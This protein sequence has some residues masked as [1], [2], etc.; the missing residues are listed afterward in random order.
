MLCLFAF[1]RLSIPRGAGKRSA[2]LLAHRHF[3]CMS[4]T[5]AELY[6]VVKTEFERHVAPGRCT[7]DGQP[8]GHK[9]VSRWFRPLCNALDAR[10]AGYSLPMMSRACAP[11]ARH[12]EASPGPRVQASSPAAPQTRR[13]PPG[14]S[15]TGA[16]AQI[17]QTSSQLHHAGD[18]GREDAQARHLEAADGRGVVPGTLQRVARVARQVAPARRPRGT[19]RRREGATSGRAVRRGGGVSSGLP[20][21][22]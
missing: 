17:R 19:W 12:H 5:D 6:T 3:V 14:P 11:A 20:P 9:T 18:V 10:Q 7:C 4:L 13:Q 21:S 1:P 22:H 15:G 16:A 2:L 8:T